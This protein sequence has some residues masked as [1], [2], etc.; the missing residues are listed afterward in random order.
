MKLLYTILFFLDTLALIL[1]SYLF[2]KLSGSGM[3][4]V[5]FAVLLLAIVICIISLIFILVHYI[6]LPSSNSLK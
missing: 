2:L 1:F 3:S 4:E 5:T 6:E